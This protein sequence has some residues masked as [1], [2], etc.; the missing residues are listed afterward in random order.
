MELETAGFLIFMI[1][2][3]AITKSTM[4]EGAASTNEKTDISIRAECRRVSIIEAWC[5]II[6]VSGDLYHASSLSLKVVH[7]LCSYS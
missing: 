2:N 1:P 3:N 6:V 5:H 4:N 7:P